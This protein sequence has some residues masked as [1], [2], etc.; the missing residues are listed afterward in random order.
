MVLWMFDGEYEGDCALPE[1]HD[2]A[3][4]DDIGTTWRTDE[5]GSTDYDTIDL[6][7]DAR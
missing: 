1:G 7:A 3:H 2:G 4:C 6:P 5:D